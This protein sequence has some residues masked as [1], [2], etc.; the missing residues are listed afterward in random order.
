[1]EVPAQLL[2]SLMITKL[3]PEN[4]FSKS[5]DQNANST[6]LLCCSCFGRPKPKGKRSTEEDLKA[7]MSFL[8]GVSLEQLFN[9]A[10]SVRT[11]ME[12]ENLPKPKTRALDL[13]KKAD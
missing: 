2:N 1:M 12:E 7:A 13:P 8:Q 4:N 3:L 10:E 6:G 9:C 11:F 5:C